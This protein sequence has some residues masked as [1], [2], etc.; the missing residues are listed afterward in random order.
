M[1][2]RPYQQLR[3]VIA[4]RVDNEPIQ[5]QTQDLSTK[6]LREALAIH[7]EIAMAPW[8]SKDE[9]AHP[10]EEGLSTL[11]TVEQRTELTL[12]IANITEVMRKQIDEVFDIT[13]PV[14]KDPSQALHITDE[15]PNLKDGKVP[16]DIPE[17]GKAR[18]LKEKDAAELPDAKLQD[19]KKDALVFFH[20][21]Q[22]E[23]VGRVGEV[24]NAKQSTET[25]IKEAVS[26]TTPDTA[27]PP[28][29][30]V[31]SKLPAQN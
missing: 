30:K 25:Q 9:S 14:A 7:P 17:E 5:H 26:T 27:P 24:V 12:L 3:N 20:Q 11:L 6:I 29:N 19:L 13:L 23:V 2:E 31:V 8:T 28:D 15:N 21:W 18:Q 16:S 10:K 22:E 4:P 1:R